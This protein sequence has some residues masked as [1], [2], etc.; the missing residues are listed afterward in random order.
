M[1]ENKDQTKSDYGIFSRSGFFYDIA[2][3]WVEI[4][5]YG[6]LGTKHTNGM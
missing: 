2:K 6:R 3:V 1:R 5:N 4:F